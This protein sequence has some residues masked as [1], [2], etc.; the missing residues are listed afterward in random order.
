MSLL[1]V[2]NISQRIKQHS[3]KTCAKALDDIYPL[4]ETGQQKKS[5]AMHVSKHCG[6]HITMQLLHV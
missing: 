6:G 4:A 1:Q 2:T 3:A 5:T